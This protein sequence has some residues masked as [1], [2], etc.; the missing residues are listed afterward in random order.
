MIAGLISSILA[1]FIYEITKDNITNWIEKRQQKRFF[2]ETRKCIDEFCR[3]NKSNTYLDTSAFEYF[4]RNTRFVKKIVER[5]IATKLD[6]SKTQFVIEQIEIARDIANREGIIF[7]NN[8]EQIIKELFVIID[9]RVGDYYRNSL[10]PEQRFIMTM[11]LENLSKLHDTVEN[12]QCTSQAND[13]QILEGIDE[14]KS[15]IKIS[16]TKASIIAELFAKEI[17]NGRFKEFDDLA[18]AIKDRSEDLA[19]YHNC[20]TDIMYSEDCAEAVKKLKDIQSLLVRDSAIRI[21]LPILLF[22]RENFDSL[23]D[24]V[25]SRSLREIIECLVKNEYDGIITETVSCEKGL[26]IHSFTINKKLLVEEEWLTKQVVVMLLFDKKIRNIYNSLELGKDN[27]T[28]LTEIL[29]ADRKV[30][31]H[32]GEYVFKDN[33]VGLSELLDVL[34][35]KKSI[36]DR[37]CGCIRAFYYSVL[38]KINLVLNKIEDADRLI[39]EELKNYRPL[40]DYI[41]AVKIEKNEIDIADLCEYAIKNDSYWLIRNYFAVKKNAQELI[42]F[43][44]N[45]EELFEKDAALFFMYIGALKVSGLYDERKTQLEKLSGKFDFVYEYWNEILDIDP[46][47]QRQKS[48]VAACRDGK[49]RGIFA[50]SEYL[51]IERLLNLNEYEIAGVYIN[52]H[53]KVGNIDFRIKK[54]K[55]II[56]QEEKNDIEALKWYKASFLENQRDVYV[57]DSLLTLSLMNNRTVDKA[58]IDAAIDADTSRLHML[59]AAYNLLEGNISEARNENIRAILM[60]E[61]NNNPALGQFLA[62]RM[63]S[64]RTDDT[65]INVIKGGTAACCKNEAGEQCWLCVYENNILPKSP[66]NWNGDYHV[67]KDDAAGLGFLRKTKGKHVVIGTEDFE[68][69][70]IIPI[71]AYFFR[72]C[73]SKMTQNGLAREICLPSKDG[74]LDIS[75]FHEWLVKNTPDEKPALD[76]LEQYNNIREVP[77]PL[78]VCK[79]YTGLSY[80]QF[81]DMILSSPAF[82]IREAFQTS[83]QARKYIITFS[84][85]V[86]LFKVGIPVED[87]VKAGGTIMESTMRQVESDVSEIIKE[88]DRDTVAYFGVIDKKPFLNQVDDLG[89]EYWL[90]EAGLLKRFC[91]AIPIVKSENDLTGSFFGEFDSKVLLGICDYDAI[92][93]VT[94]N[95]EYSLV[96]IEAMI[97]SIASNDAVQLKVTSIPDWL[98]NMGVDAIDLLSYVKKLMDQGCLTSITKDVLKHLSK[99]VKNGDEIT[100]KNIYSEFDEMLSSIDSYPEKHKTVAIQALSEVVTSFGGDATN[101]DK[102][103]LRILM[104]NILFLRKQRIEPFID[105]N[106]YLSL[107]LV[108]TISD[109]QITECILRS[110]TADFTQ[111]NGPI[112]LMNGRK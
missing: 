69:I 112:P 62:I 65:K 42:S 2:K 33:E 29:M 39:P 71:D 85:L 21:A 60:S 83:K 82:F 109:E 93:F 3:K 32:V 76:C 7:S 40:S 48:F 49:M 72:I 87:I 90:K 81:V 5:A 64:E 94:Q 24:I 61:G 41:L 51:I 57:I 78:F 88:Y 84:A 6:E 31:K 36:Y 1:S 80:L 19:I 91:E 96:T 11:N 68:V 75:T 46:S 16:D 66:Y 102:R 27:E 54:Y 79:N 23:L 10:S 110:Q 34:Q 14:I 99:T 13:R 101:L 74:K 105:E 89:K 67:F 59:V 111:P 26:E 63:R 17:C 15:G 108:N 52:K 30:E 56:L 38:V 70:D 8:E 43:C 47:E 106:G 12:F 55:A 107:A 86:A 22:R 73:T 4:I 100:K 18:T 9:D 53:E 77:M 20:L 98:V 28:W 95:D 58:V 92:S 97:Y 25:D 35:E 104:H 44:R 50:S 37:L 103:I 45:H